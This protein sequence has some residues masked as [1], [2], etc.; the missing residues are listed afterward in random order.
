MQ[1]AAQIYAHGCVYQLQHCL[2]PVESLRRAVAALA[3]KPCQAWLTPPPSVACTPAPQ[4]QATLLPG[5]PQHDCPCC[6]GCGC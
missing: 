5:G 2:L 4:N 6:G 1:G 3:G